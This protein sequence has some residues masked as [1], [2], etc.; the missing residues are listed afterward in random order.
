MARGEA[1]LQGERKHPSGQRGPRRETLVQLCW[2]AGALPDAELEMKAPIYLS[3]HLMWDW[4]GLG[5]LPSGRVCPD[6]PSCQSSPI[7]FQARLL[8][9]PLRCS[10]EEC[11]GLS[12]A[13]KGSGAALHLC[14]AVKPPSTMGH[15]LSPTINW[16]HFTPGTKAG[17]LP[18]LELSVLLMEA[19]TALSLMLEL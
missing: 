4:F 10:P 1:W 17:C 15:L 2:P 9:H 16:V 14:V 12:I 6:A 3:I 13:G 19:G 7:P 11:P 18:G 8:Q 5:T